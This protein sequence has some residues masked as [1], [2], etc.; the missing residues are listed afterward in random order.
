MLSSWSYS[1]RSGS[2]WN[3]SSKRGVS[4]TSVPQFSVLL[5]STQ[6]PKFKL[7]SNCV[8]LELILLFYRWINADLE[9]LH[10]DTM[11][12]QLISNRAGHEFKSFVSKSNF[13]SLITT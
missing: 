10:D 3:F 1:N 9:N 12:V 11:T 2:V 6:C 7:Y 13:L 4:F 5:K 8:S